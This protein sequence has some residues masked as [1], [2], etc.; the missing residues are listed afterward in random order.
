VAT[1]SE[2]RSDAGKPPVLDAEL[3]THPGEAF[4]QALEARDAGDALLA[5]ALLAAISK[6]YVVV[7]DYADLYRIDLMVSEGRFQEAL[8]LASFWS[9]E[10][11]ILRPRVQALA[12]DAWAGLGDE[13]R[14]RQSWEQALSGEEDMARRSALRTKIGRS[15]LRAGEPSRAVD[16]LIEVWTHDPLSDEEEEVDRLLTELELH[17]ETSKR[18]GTAWRKR[19][20]ELFRRR[21]NEEALEAYETALAQPGIPTVDA[22]RARNGRA[23]TLFRL[24][25]YTEAAEAYAAL[26]QVP[27]HRIERARAIARAGDPEA[28]A[29]QLEK[30]GRSTKGSD[31]RRALFL[32]ALLWEGED[33][34]DKANRLYAGLAAGGSRSSQADAARWRLGW[35][36][37]R[38]HDLETAARYLKPLSDGAR[39][40]I[41]DL[42]ARYW[43][44]RTLEQQGDPK[45]RELF[46]DM[47]RSF[48]LSYYGWR[49]SSH[50]GTDEGGEPEAPE[51]G[52][53][54]EKGTPALAPRDTERPRILLQAGLVDDAR[55]ELD[56]LFARARG[57]ED[58]LLLARLFSEAGDYH[59]PQR[60]I[61]DAYQETLARGPSDPLELW[62][63]AWPLPWADLVAASTRNRAELDPALVYAIMREESGYRPEVRSVSGARGLLQL[64][65]ETAERVA[66]SLELSGFDPDR[67]FEP[68]VNIELGAAYLSELLQ[69]F[70]GNASAAIGSYN[71]GPHR[72]V[73]WL[74][75]EPVDDDEWVEAIPF[76]QT[77]SYVKR[78]LR[79][80]HAYQVLY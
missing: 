5:N 3:L 40:T 57:L 25:R 34:Q 10:D 74:E 48:P 35:A 15:L 7:A 8:D 19:A 12:G 62:Q 79:S 45:A 24:R 80:M 65:P 43:Y 56:L 13:V 49:A 59:R 23:N 39:D 38:A 76:D 73:R 36:A 29:A 64:M 32:A 68:D 71:A 14:A 58:R 37:Y 22:R 26:P 66:G 70:D 1:G 54:I 9:H 42:R 16:V 18:D 21:H 72:V 46:R 67:L 31:G 41:D 50:T 61:V 33:R 11:S 20:D 17:L 4:A 55:V 44:A 53:E 28:G 78:V 52:R 63:F 51:A 75:G 27:E 2:S 47:A 77:R 69:R 30:I 6:R 60:L